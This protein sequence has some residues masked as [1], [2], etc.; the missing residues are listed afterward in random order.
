MNDKWFVLFSIGIILIAGIVII[1]NRLVSI[2]DYIATITIGEREYYT[3]NYEINNEVISIYN[4][5]SRPFFVG[6][7]WHE[8]SNDEVI[9]SSTWKVVEQ[10]K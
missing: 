9:I 2:P 4:T 3:S 7:Q 6:I 8:K 10:N 5:W 1:L